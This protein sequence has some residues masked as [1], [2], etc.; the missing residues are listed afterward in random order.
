MM[1]REGGYAVI[2]DP[3]RPTVELSTFSCR[4]C[5]RVVHVKPKQRPE[6]LGGLCKIC[7]GLVCSE[8]VGKGCDPLEERLR[9]EEERYHTL[10]SYGL[11]Q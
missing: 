3:E 5:N 6:D 8:C 7:M 2:T 10:R 11:V 4:H 1:R 9:R